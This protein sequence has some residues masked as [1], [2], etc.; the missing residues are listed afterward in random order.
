[1]ASHQFLINDFCSAVYNGTLPTV[2]A[3][4]A[5]RFTVPGIVAYESIK[6]G[7]V[8]LDVPDFGDPPKE[9]A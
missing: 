6:Q 1:M 9:G 3:W 2:N 5:A 7:G 4:L 8:T